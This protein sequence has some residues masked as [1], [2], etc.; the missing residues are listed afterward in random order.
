MYNLQTETQENKNFNPESD[1]RVRDVSFLKRALKKPELGA[2]SGAI[3]VFIF[4]D[5]RPV[6]RECLP[7]TEF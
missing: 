7:P 3:L 5:L 6:T 2:I 4:L 1:E